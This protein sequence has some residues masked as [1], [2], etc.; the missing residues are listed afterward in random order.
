MKSDEYYQKLAAIYRHEYGDKPITPELLES[1]YC[2]LDRLYR[3]SEYDYTRRGKG[4]HLVPLDIGQDEESGDDDQFS[5]PAWEGDNN[6]GV[7]RMIAELDNE[8]PDQ[9]EHR[10]Q[11]LATAA[12]VAAVAPHALYTLCLI[13]KNG[14]NRKES[15]WELQRLTSVTERKR[16]G[17]NTCAIL[18][19]C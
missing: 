11:F 12:I 13:V 14:T 16:Q 17:K 18:S 2:R 10:E 3:M 15:I 5:S 7:E 8:I 6:A 4:R 1:V 19:C 9:N